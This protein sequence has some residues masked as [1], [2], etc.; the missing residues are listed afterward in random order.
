MQ[1]S[2]SESMGLLQNSLH[3]ISPHPLEECAAL[4]KAQLGKPMGCNFERV[5]GYVEQEDETTYRFALSQ[6]RGG[7]LTG[8]LRAREFGTTE[9]EASNGF[10]TGFMIMTLVPAGIILLFGVLSHQ[11][12][13][14]K[15]LIGLL[16]FL[17]FFGV[18]LAVLIL[19]NRC[20]VL[21]FVKRTLKN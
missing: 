5:L 2:K 3:F 6:R 8:H 19:Y 1:P 11:P 14:L 17:T 18:I 16:C 21:W 12:F 4:L 20:E 13:P 15:D 9:V 7:Q 10:D